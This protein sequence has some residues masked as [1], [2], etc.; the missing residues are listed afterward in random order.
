MAQDGAFLTQTIEEV[1]AWE[2]ALM[3]KAFDLGV[4]ATDRNNSA[5]VSKLAI[6][7]D[8]KTSAE[9]ATECVAKFLAV[10][11]KA[12][13]PYGRIQSLVLG[14]RR[15]GR[16]VRKFELD[17]TVIQ[18]G[19]EI[20][21][22][23]QALRVAWAVLS[24]FQRLSIHVNSESR[25]K[26]WKD[27]GNEQLKRANDLSIELIV[28]AEKANMRRELI[29]A[30][31]YH[32]RFVALELD[33]TADAKKPPTEKEDELRKVELYHLDECLRK[34]DQ[35]PSAEYLRKDVQEARLLLGSGI[36]LS[37]VTATGPS[38]EKEAVYSALRRTYSDT[39]CWYYCPSGHPFSAGGAGAPPASARC[40]DC[41]E[42]LASPNE[43]RTVFSMLA[44]LMGRF[45]I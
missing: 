33:C 12:E 32:A 6:L 23:V 19:F 40:A 9:Q 3:Q 29:E 28:D 15:R 13:Q 1:S 16:H 34:I 25:T 30:F 26:W 10:V 38:T 8:Y 36:R 35:H 17:N 5:Y 20:R 24:N 31:I 37:F 21:G 4:L 41:N 14:A 42:L 43:H 45:V 7:E 39:A 11:A 27:W 44:R 2:T 22:R 18:P